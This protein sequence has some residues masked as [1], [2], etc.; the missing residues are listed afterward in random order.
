MTGLEIKEAL[1]A[2]QRVY[3][4]LIVSSFP[5]W[6]VPLKNLG[7][8]FVFID[9][10]HIAIDREKLSWMC[11]AYREAGLAPIV[12]TVA[13]PIRCDDGYRRRSGRH[14]RSV[15]RGEPRAQGSPAGLDHRMSIQCSTPGSPHIH[16]SE[17]FSG[18]QTKTSHL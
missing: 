18:A 11:H 3:G 15:H 12:R 4:T 10:E 2:V 6:V 16:A 9:T 1:R 5:R 13:R 8:D 17:K 14:C 7:L